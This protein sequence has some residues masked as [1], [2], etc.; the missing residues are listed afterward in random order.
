MIGRRS[1]FMANQL[2]R[3]QA[4]NCAEAALYE[5]FNRIRAGG[6]DPTSDFTD[7]VDVKV[8]DPDNPGT[9][10][11]VTVDVTYTA[12]TPNEV[13]ATVDYDNIRR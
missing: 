4:I 2:K 10:Y 3:A 5:T 8:T 11:D 13:S 7:T 1:T 12:G 6:Q 9:T